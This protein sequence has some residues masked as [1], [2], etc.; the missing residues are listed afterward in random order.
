[1]G[2]FSD[3]FGVRMPITL[4]SVMLGAGYIAAASAT[5]M[6]QFILAQAVMIGML[7]ADGQLRLDAPAPVPRSRRIETLI[8]LHPA[9]ACQR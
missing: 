4:G 2:R 7:V 1:M 6:W 3:R 5:T 8:R 9:V